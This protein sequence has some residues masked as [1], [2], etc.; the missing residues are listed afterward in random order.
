MAGAEGAALAPRARG[1]RGGDG[2]DHPRA[3]SWVG[4]AGLA[5]TSVERLTRAGGTRDELEL[6]QAEALADLRHVLGG[7]CT[8]AS[9]DA[10]AGHLRDALKP[11]RQVVERHG[12]GGSHLHGVVTQAEGH[13]AGWAAER[14]ARDDAGWQALRCVLAYHVPRPDWGASERDATGRVKP[15]MSGG[16]AV[17]PVHAL[18]EALSRWCARMRIAAVQIG[19]IVIPFRVDDTMASATKELKPRVTTLMHTDDEASN[20]TLAAIDNIVGSS[21]RDP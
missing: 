12:G 13:I 11:L 6:P 4:F 9:V 19:V 5:Q 1:G 16:G 21:R 15:R 7:H 20:Q 3:R 17:L 10:R 14:A 18:L 2:Q 8:D